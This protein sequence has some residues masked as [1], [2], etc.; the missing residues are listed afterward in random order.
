MSNFN[1]LVYDDGDLIAGFVSLCAAVAFVE[2][3]RHPGAI[4]PIPVDLVDP[5][6]GEVLDT[7]VN[8]VWERGR[9]DV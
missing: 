9:Y 8:G 6:T 3:W 4:R 2:E 1:Y 7:W 5:E